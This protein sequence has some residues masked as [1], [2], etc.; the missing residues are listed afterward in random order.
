M[1]F[2]L[3][4]TSTSDQIILCG[5]FNIPEA[6]WSFDN[7]DHLNCFIATCS[8][9]SYKSNFL[10]S[11]SSLPLFQK[12]GIVNYNGRYLDL[13]FTDNPDSFIVNRASP[14]LKEDLPHHPSLDVEL[15]IPEEPPSVQRN[16]FNFE[17]NFKKA[18]VNLLNNLLCNVNWTPIYNC[19]DINNAV[20]LFNAVIYDC[21]ELCVPK[22]RVNAD[23]DHCLKWV[24]PQIQK[25]R[26]KK[27][28]LHMKLRRR[29]SVEICNTYS[30]VR[31][32]LSSKTKTAYRNY[33]TKVKTNIYKDSSSFLTTKG[34]LN[35]TIQQL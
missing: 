10:D 28:A 31:R 1:Q 20:S 12:N 6:D 8:N 18:D 11:I 3:N 14:L 34:N 24:T 33:L 35:L 2:I 5:D 19:K 22:R 4:N 9:S 27:T 23:S 16:K 30:R 15:I 13:I 29:F 7:E 26:N 32:E 21:F 17:Y 25:L